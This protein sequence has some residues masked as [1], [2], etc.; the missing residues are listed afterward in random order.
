M[1]RTDQ[2]ARGRAIEAHRYQSRFALAKVAGATGL[3]GAAAGI[4]LAWTTVAPD[5]HQIAIRYVLT[6]AKQTIRTAIIPGAQ[7]Q[8]QLMEVDGWAIVEDPG[9]AAMILLARRMAISGGCLAIL[10]AGGL[11]TLQ[12]RN[13]ISIAEKAAMDEVRRGARRATPKQ[14]AAMLAPAGKRVTGA[15]PI[16]IGGV[17]LPAG[18][19]NR[20]LLAIGA[21]GTGKTS[22]LIDLVHQIAKRG[23]AVF[24]YDPDGSYVSR[25]YD[26]DRGDVILN[27]WDRRTARWALID[28]IATLADAHRVAAILLPKPA[29]AGESAF[30]W[31]EAR[32]LLAHILYH[33]ATTGGTLDDLA[34]LLNGGS[35]DLNE[36]YLDRLRAI[37]RGTP[38]AT[39]FTAGGDKATA[40]VVFMI[41]IAARSV[42]TLAAVSRNAAA[43]SFDRFIVALDQAHGPKPFVFLCCPRRNRDLGTPIVAAW[44]DAAASAI[45]QRPPDRG[46]NVWM[47]IDELASLPPVQ[48]LSNLMP[49]GRKYRACVTIAF[50]S[51]AQLNIAY[52]EAA[53]QV[54][55]GQT[56]TQLLMRLGDSPSAEWAA[57]LVGQ[58]EV[59][60]MR[61][62]ISLDTQ[63]KG[64]RGSIAPDR[65]RETLLMDSDLTML[66]TGAAFLRIA[67]Y[68]VARI[69][70]PPPVEADAVFMAPAFVDAP[71]ATAKIRIAEALPVSPRIE[72]GDDWLPKVGAF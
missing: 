56:S 53:A 61:P 51:L 15:P 30:W 62:T 19:E 18:I 24:L 3:L 41:G 35:V 68:P 36:N 44:L 37:V 52:G 55:T 63:A 11:T 28:D 1:S 12:R 31:D 47:I 10:F 69:Q 33:L 13:W 72:D 25:F 20:H 66:P 6:Q 23:E 54:I 4:A 22:F 57:R 45:L 42:H 21:T 40:S 49:E 43:F 71:E 48:S 58:A 5:V 32:L 67:G 2:A 64:D 65:H 70:L 17:A 14:L 34:D 38:A 50:Q 29:N 26:P 8:S 9:H 59:E 7:V 60:G 46:T 16:M 27:C 39:I